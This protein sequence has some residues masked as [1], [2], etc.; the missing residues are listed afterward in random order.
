MTMTRD[1]QVRIR[2]P[3][4][5]AS[6]PLFWLRRDAEVDLRSRRLLASILAA[7]A[8][9]RDVRRRRLVLAA[10]RMLGVQIEGR[11]GGGLVPAFAA[12]GVSAAAAGEAMRRGMD[13]VVAALLDDRRRGRAT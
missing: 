12:L 4:T 13:G 3:S 9:E 6:D 8:A 2:P 5:S 1:L 10:Q 7:Q 11:I